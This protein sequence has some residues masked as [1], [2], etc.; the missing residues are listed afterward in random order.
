MSLEAMTCNTAREMLQKGDYDGGVMAHVGEC[1]RCI[2]VALNDVLPS[3][4]D[5]SMPPAFGSQVLA[6]LSALPMTAAPPVARKALWPAIIAGSAVPAALFLPQLSAFAQSL[7]GVAVL[8][9]AGM[10]V[11]LIIVWVLRGNRC[12]WVLRR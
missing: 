12:T 2:D 4:E 7:W 11:S 8:G 5:I 9:A 3:R 6:R 1:D 10:E